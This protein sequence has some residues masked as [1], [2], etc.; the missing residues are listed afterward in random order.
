MTA[1]IAFRPAVFF[2]DPV[3]SD[4][5]VDISDLASSSISGP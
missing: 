5:T 2:F 3:F 1:A 4:E